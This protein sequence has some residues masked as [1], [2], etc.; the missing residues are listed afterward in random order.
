M[1]KKFNCPLEVTLY[2]LKNK[3]VILILRELFTETKRF[4][5]LHKGIAGISQ[6]VLTQQLREMEK[7][8]L[9]N[10]TVFPVVPPKVEY[11]LTQRGDSLKP[12][13]EIMGEWGRK[14]GYQDS[15]NILQHSNK[16]DAA[17]AKNCAVN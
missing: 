8:G 17:K 12:I 3:W 9:I 16:A 7:N 15:T 4:G 13:L 11:S 2:Y 6:K 5:T 14:N 1:N 10:R